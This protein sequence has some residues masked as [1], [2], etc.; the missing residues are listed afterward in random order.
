MK[1]INII[2]FFLVFSVSLSGMTIEDISQKYSNDLEKILNNNDLDAL[3]SIKFS[4]QDKQ[5]VD[6]SKDLISEKIG[7]NL[8]NGFF[9]PIGEYSQTIQDKFGALLQDDLILND[10]N[11]SGYKNDLKDSF[12]DGF[13]EE[14]LKDIQGMD[15]LSE[16]D[17][18]KL[19]EGM[20][21]LNNL[22]DLENYFDSQEIMTQ[23]CDSEG[24]SIKKYIPKE[25]ADIAGSLE[26]SLSKTIS[27]F[28]CACSAPLTNAFKKIQ[29]HI[30]DDKLNPLYANL[31]SLEN[32][33][34]GNVDSVSAKIPLLLKSNDFYVIKVME[35][36]E[37]LFKLD[38]LLQVER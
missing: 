17:K 8:G 35:A 10:L 9:T 25:L 12:V 18:N 16:L 2:I 28:N 5:F 13:K 7:G 19:I 37:Y 32:T 31:T 38:Q 4:E 24:C 34:K 20:N 27:S 1:K 26:K 23:I 29:E 3:K 36:K 33:I 21:D 6:F 22:G 15:F 14:A 30:I 11:F